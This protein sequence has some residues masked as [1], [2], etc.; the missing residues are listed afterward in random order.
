MY[1]KGEPISTEDF[2]A[3]GE[4][5]NLIVWVEHYAQT[6]HGV[7]EFSGAVR[8]VKNICSLEAMFHYDDLGDSLEFNEEYAA[9]DG[10]C[11]MVYEEHGEYVQIEVFEVVKLNVPDELKRKYVGAH[12]ERLENNPDELAFVLAWQRMCEANPDMYRDLL[13]DDVEP[14]EIRAVNTIIQWLGSPVGQSFPAT[15]SA[16]CDERR[17]RLWDNETPE[18][19]KYAV[20]SDL[21]SRE[22]ETPD[23][24]GKTLPYCLPCRAR[25]IVEG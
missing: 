6:K 13:G 2:R 8:V 3:M 24:C 18:T 15:A 22:C 10:P 19:P 23:E 1:T 21:A 9:E 7:L 12:A 17:E 11:T 14:D 5:D 25:S 16:V 20:I 4:M